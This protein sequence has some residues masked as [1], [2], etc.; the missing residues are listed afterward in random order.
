VVVGALLSVP[1]YASLNAHSLGF[2]LPKLTKRTVEA[3]AIDLLKPIYEWDDQLPAFGIKVLPSGSRRYILKYRAGAGGRSATQ[4]WVTLGTHG[5]ITCD[6]ARE[7]AQQTLAAVAKG[8]DPQANK[9]RLRKSPRMS[10]VWQRFESEQLPHKKKSTIKDYRQFWRDI[11]APELCNKLVKDVRSETIDRLH[12]KHMSTPYQANRSLAFLSRLFTLAEAWG[13]REFGSNPCK[14]VERFKELPRERYLTSD[15]LGRLGETLEKMLANEELYPEAGAAIRLLLLTGARLNEIL[16]ARWEWVSFERRLIELP[17][18]K[19]GKKNL[20]LSLEAL[21]VLQWIRAKGRDADSPF[22]LPGRTRGKPLNNLY[23]SWYRVCRN[24]KLSGVRIH[25]LRHT[26]ASIA[27]GKGASL[28]LIGRL[29]GHTQA[30][31]TL[32][33]AHVDIDPA[34]RLADE[35][36]ATVTAALTRRINAPSG[37]SNVS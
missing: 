15:E 25:D 12:K 6:Q 13:M 29:L 18:S 30:Q 1:R 32:R 19:T 24:A 36:G 16:K 33:Y 2:T 27:A 10:D 22:I 9:F 5:A 35:L 23:K 31:T 17:E 20:F 34:L 37:G 21:K 26:A 11:V 4:R 8:D 14:H 28:S 3:V 7:L